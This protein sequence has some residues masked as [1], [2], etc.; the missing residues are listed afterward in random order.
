MII[1]S[2]SKTKKKNLYNV[3]ID[4]KV[5][6]FNEDIIIEFNLYKGKEIDDELLNKALS[7]NSIN[8]YY[9]KALNYAA[10]YFKDSYEKSL[11]E[12]FLKQ[13]KN[14]KNNDK[15]CFTVE[16]YQESNEIPKTISE[17]DTI[18]KYSNGFVVF[19]VGL[20]SEAYKDNYLTFF[21]TFREY[22][23]KYIHYAKI[24]VKK[25]IKSKE[26]DFKAKYEKLPNKF[27]EN[28]E[29]KNLVVRWFKNGITKNLKSI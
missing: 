5:Y 3:I 17:I 12:I 11:C 21:V 8:D 25:S 7:S 6:E 26:K 15:K 2:V 28:A 10:R 18:S 13:F 16:V 23:Q 22:I 9:N 19:S 1:E 4:K 24:V 20:N 14:I 27:I 29:C